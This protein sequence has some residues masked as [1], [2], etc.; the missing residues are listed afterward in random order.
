MTIAITITLTLTIGLYN[1]DNR[2]DS[3]KSDLQGIIKP[4]YDDDGSCQLR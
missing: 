4:I 1:N 2:S 3:S